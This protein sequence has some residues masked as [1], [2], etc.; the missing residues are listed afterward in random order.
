MKVLNLSIFIVLADQLTKLWIK[1]IQIPAIGLRFAGVPIGSSRPI[2]GNI[3]RLTYI[4]NPGMAFGIDIGGK[5]FFSLF[6]I[7]ASLGILFYMYKAR[8]ENL[9][10]RISL[11]MILGG[12][13]GNL[14]DRVFYGLLFHEGPLFYGR[15][16]DFIDADFFT[17]NFFG[18]HLSRFPV[19]NLADASV[20]CGVILMIFSHRRTAE[21]GTSPGSGTP[22]PVP[23]SEADLGNPDSTLT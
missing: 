19:F 2:F 4:E 3:L 9:A 6:S 17:L 15:V 10:F 21:T 20:T 22:D 5:I 7:L 1:G 16:V 14:I 12:A 13:I 8:H 18:Y 23:V 11:A